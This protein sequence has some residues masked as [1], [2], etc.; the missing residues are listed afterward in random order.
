M[1]RQATDLVNLP[2]SHICKEGP[3]SKIY[4]ELKNKQTNK[5]TKI[6]RKQ[7]TTSV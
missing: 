1:K 5:Q 4:H 6:L 7:M 2:A 3:E